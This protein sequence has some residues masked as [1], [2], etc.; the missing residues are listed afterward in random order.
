[1]GFY[2]VAKTEKGAERATRK[3]RPMGEKES[4]K[5]LRSLAAVNER[6]TSVRSPTL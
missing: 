1:M 2:L 5:W 4:G 6:S 3:Q